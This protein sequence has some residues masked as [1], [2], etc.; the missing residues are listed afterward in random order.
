M[1][2]LLTQLLLGPPGRQ[3]SRVVLTVLTPCVYALFALL[4]HSEALDAARK[5]VAA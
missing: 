5:P 2:A 1:D 3:R 4:Q